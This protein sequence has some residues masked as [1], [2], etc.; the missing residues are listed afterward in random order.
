VDGDVKAGRT[1]FSAGVTMLIGAVGASARPPAPEPEP[2]ASFDLRESITASGTYLVDL[3]GREIGFGTGFGPLAW[4]TDETDL[5]L[6]QDAPDPFVGRL[7]FT[8]DGDFGGV[9]LDQ[10]SVPISSFAALEQRDV[11]LDGRP[12]GFGRGGPAPYA[13]GTFGGAPILAGVKLSGEEG[14]LRFSA[15]SVQLDD[16]QQLGHKHVSVGRVS[17]G[18]SEGSS[19]GLIATAGAPGRHG[20]NY[21]VGSDLNL[22]STRLVENRVVEGNLWVQQSLTTGADADD[23]DPSDTAL[24]VRLGYP[25]DR[26]RWEFAFTQVG[27]SF[28]AAL[29]SVGRRGMREYAG[30]WRFRLP[31][32]GLLRSIETGVDGVMLTD[33]EG[34]VGQR[35]VTVRPLTLEMATSDRIT[36]QYTFNRETL[37]SERP[38]YDGVVLPAGEYEYER[39]ELGLAT[40]PARPVR[41]GITIAGGDWYS[42]RRI[43][44]GVGAS[45]RV[46]PGVDLAVEYQQNEVELEQAAFET[47]IVRGQMSMALAPG[48][49]ISNSI[50]YDRMS[51]SMSVSSQ[52]RLR[53][54]D[55]NELNLGFTQT[56]AGGGLGGLDPREGNV[57]AQLRWSSEF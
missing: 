24:G 3:A 37:V 16:R 1:I 36:F 10:R 34:D 57:A 12:F 55:G 4:A 40:S 50:Q 46:V 45:V 47:E 52:I 17:L 21:V 54:A 28:D 2:S 41:V 30:N 9:G 26:V 38:V 48:S 39:Y 42:G 32:S 22:R 53:I 43:E 25:N 13:P 20:D 8:V 15:M 11:F 23:G 18:L 33:L 44:T 51:E 5:E 6:L 27:E 14:P 56:I 19:V 49:A 7:A 31:A 29:G 35:R